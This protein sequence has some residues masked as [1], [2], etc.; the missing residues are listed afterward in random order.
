MNKAKSISLSDIVSILSAVTDKNVES[1]KVTDYL[2]K[3]L[4]LSS[5]EIIDFIFELERYY[6]SDIKISDFFNETNMS[7]TDTYRDFSIA[8]VIKIVEKKL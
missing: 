7:S 4:D 1:I 3:D 2:V 8:L 6:S 5:I